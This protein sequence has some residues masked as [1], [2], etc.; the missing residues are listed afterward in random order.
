[1]KGV[2]ERL[3]HTQSVR[4]EHRKSKLKFSECLEVLALAASVSTSG[5]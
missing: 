4:T 2:R 1:M 3:E 5:G